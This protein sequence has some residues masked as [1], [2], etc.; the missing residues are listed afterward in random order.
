MRLPSHAIESPSR[1]DHERWIKHLEFQLGTDTNPP[2]H[3]ALLKI[4]LEAGVTLL[5]CV[6]QMVDDHD[7]VVR[8]LRSALSIAR[9]FERRLGTV[10]R[11]SGLTTAVHTDGRDYVQDWA[12]IELNP[13]RV[14][15]PDML[16]NSLPLR[17]S[18]AAHGTPHRKIGRTTGQTIGGLC[19]TSIQKTVH[20]VTGDKPGELQEFVVRGEAKMVVSNFPCEDYQTWSDSGDSGACVFDDQNTVAGHFWGGDREPDWADYGPERDIRFLR[21]AVRKMDSAHFF[22]PIQ[23]VMDDIE[24]K[25]KED[26][27]NGIRIQLCQI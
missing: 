16:S 13:N 14:E 4:K 8:D 2:P 10:F 11:T 19:G 26:L 6:Q 12:L 7:E 25:L 18:P 24:A 21:R 23:A 20:E 1:S 17:P 5:P 27:G 3:I 9:A 15:I 22:T